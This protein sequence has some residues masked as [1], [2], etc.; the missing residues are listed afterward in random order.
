MKPF[1]ILT[2]LVFG[3]LTAP[4]AAQASLTN[5]QIPRLVQSGLSEDFIL[6]LIDQQGSNLS[7]DTAGLVELKNSGVSE[8]V[9]AAIVKKNP[10]QEPLTSYGLIQLGKAQF[11]DG[12]V[13]DLI[14]QQ[15][16][17]Q[18]GQVATDA[19]RLIELKRAGLSEPVISEVVR[20]NPPAE[21]VTGDA[22]VHLLKAEFSEGFI[23]DLLKRRPGKFTIDSAKIVEL[24]QAGVSE[25]I[26]ATMLEQ[27]ATR[28]LPSGTEITVRLI[29]SID[30]E[31]NDEG[32]EFRATLE[33]P[34]KLGDTVVAP[35]GSNAKV[36]LV[37]EKDSGKLTGRT[38]LSVRLLSVAVDGK[39]VPV[40]TSRVTEGSGSRGARTAK[41]AAAV[42]AVG[43]I[44]GA[45]AGGGQGA[46]I[47]AGAGAAAGAGSQVFMKGQRVRIPSETVLTFTT[48]GI[49][50]FR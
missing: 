16:A 45:I 6:K 47:G 1:L 31:K 7:S 22:V 50:A 8:R 9:I 14:N 39:L 2:L 21:P 48:E 30:S 27:G 18:Q 38:E 3:S 15:P 32:D 35:K 19:A 4:L 23:V 40:N 24:K 17:A 44:I 20:K 29:D 10:P 46:A 41:T 28:E 25:R 5:D 43:A 34:I 26:L 37:A 42:G 13:L 36:K 33:D 12:F 11:S 49:V